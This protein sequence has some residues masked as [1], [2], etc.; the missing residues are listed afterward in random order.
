MVVVAGEEAVAVVLVV[1]R[2]AAAG[3]WVSEEAAGWVLARRPRSVP[4]ASPAPC[5]RHL[6]ALAG[7]VSRTGRTHRHPLLRKQ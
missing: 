3:V 6:W 7:A 2:A 5:R 1:R 4:A